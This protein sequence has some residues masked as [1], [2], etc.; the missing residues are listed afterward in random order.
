MLR[1]EEL[2][3]HPEAFSADLEMA[4]AEG[5]EVWGDR[6]AGYTAICSGAICIALAGDNLIGMTGIGRG[7]WLKTRHFATI[8]GVYVNRDWRGFHIAEQLLAGCEDWA[9]TNEITVISLGVNISNLPAIRSYSR[10]GFTIYSFVLRAIYYNGLYF[11]ELL[12]AKLI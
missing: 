8:R 1:L 10:S 9:K 3:L 7:H 11:D 4:A 5:S 2:S 6:I 12:M